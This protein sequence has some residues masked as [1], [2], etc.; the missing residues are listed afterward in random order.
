MDLLIGM[1]GD[2]MKH[3]RKRERAAEAELL[4]L[5]KHYEADMKLKAFLQAMKEMS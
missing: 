5:N 4:A 1:T 3:E 2:V